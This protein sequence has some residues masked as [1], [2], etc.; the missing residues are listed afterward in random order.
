MSKQVLLSVLFF[1]A[2]LITVQSA[3]A[4]SDRGTITGTVSDSTGAVISSVPVQAKNTVTGV[5]YDSATSTT[6]NYTISQLPAGSYELSMTAPGFKKYTRAGLT[7]EVAQ[8]LRVDIALGV[9][10]STESVTVTAAATL[11]NTETGDVRHD[12]R[13][14]TLDDLPVLGIG[15]SQAGSAGIRN[16]NAMVN[17]IPGTYFIA[18]AEVRI[19]GAPDNTQ[20]F[21]IEG[22]DA[23]NTG[24]PGVAAQTQPSVD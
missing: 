9:G 17:L 10:A 3:F 13:A 24:T 8:V 11:L 12:I 20:S 7:V 2:S 18:N 19:N 15:A 14:E 6:G 5:A 21:R 1:V 23:S 22:Q 4:Q 16:P